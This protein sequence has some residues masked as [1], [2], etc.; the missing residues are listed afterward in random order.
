MKTIL[1]LKDVQILDKKAQQGILGGGFGPC[2]QQSDCGSPECWVC[3]PTNN[4]GRCLLLY[5]CPDY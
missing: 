4:G 1:H 2:S 3:V 5:S